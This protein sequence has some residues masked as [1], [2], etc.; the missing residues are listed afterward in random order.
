MKKEQLSSR[1]SFEKA[2]DMHAHDLE[3]LSD[4]RRDRIEQIHREASQERAGMRRD[5]AEQWDEKLEAEKT[6]LR[7]DAP[8]PHLTPT[9]RSE[10]QT[11]SR[12][13]A[14]ELTRRASRNI[15]QAYQREERMS[16][17]LEEAAVAV[18]I[19]E[20]QHGLEAANQLDPGRGVGQHEGSDSPERSAF[21]SAPSADMDFGLSAEFYRSSAEPVH[22]RA[23]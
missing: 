17:V 10:Q 23:R 7:R 19:A 3:K 21:E 20:N 4:S 6:R 14:T 2:R 5:H 13:D 16:Y 11:A 9:G 1:E 15:E 22:G 8:A 12:M 18:V